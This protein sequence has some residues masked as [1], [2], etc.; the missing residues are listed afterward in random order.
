MISSFLFLLFI[1]SP[2]VLSSKESKETVVVFD[3][4]GCS[5]Y[6]S[7]DFSSESSVEGG[8]ETDDLFPQQIYEANPLGSNIDDRSI[9]SEKIYTPEQAM[10][11]VVQLVVKHLNLNRPEEFEKEIADIY[12]ESIEIRSILDSQYEKLE[13]IT[14]DQYF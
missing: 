8:F 14:L 10:D 2:L 3:E 6:L 13:L 11:I 4:Q 9:D 7:E 1:L 5:H 12:S